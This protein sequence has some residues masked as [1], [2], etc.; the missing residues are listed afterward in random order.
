MRILDKLNKTAHK[1]SDKLGKH[2]DKVA[3][4]LGCFSLWASGTTSRTSCRGYHEWLSYFHKELNNTDT[5][6]IL[7]KNLHL[8]YR[9]MSRLLIYIGK[10]WLFSRLIDKNWDFL[11]PPSLCIPVQIMSARQM[12]K[13][14]SQ[15]PAKWKILLTANENDLECIF[16]PTINL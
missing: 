4:P 1:R 13:W 9:T 11:T 8:L 10:S 3:S 15:H 14:S 6:H 5:H 12:K 2:L 16:H 7:Y